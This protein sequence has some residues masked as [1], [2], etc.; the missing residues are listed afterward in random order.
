[1]YKVGLA[2]PPENGEVI[3]TL[4]IDYHTPED[5]YPL[6]DHGAQILI[7]GSS[8]SACL[9]KAQII[10]ESLNSEGIPLAE[11]LVQLLEIAT[12]T[13]KT[14]QDEIDAQDNS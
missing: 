7:H 8:L 1:M 12:V 2:T 5:E 11:I 3:W 4:D 9:L 6:I 14:L 10:C 13:E